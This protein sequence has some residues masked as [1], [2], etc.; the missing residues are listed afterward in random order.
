MVFKAYIEGLPQNDNHF[1]VRIPKLEDNT[2]KEFVLSA[3]LC[4]QPGEYANYK[5][6]D[7]VFVEFEDNLLDVPVIL[8]K[9]YTGVE[10]DSRGYFKIDRL[11]VANHFEM[12]DNST[13]GGYSVKDFFGLYQR[14]EN[15]LLNNVNILV[16]DEIGDI[17]D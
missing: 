16:Y 10:D 3:L 13:L 1:L 2:T 15:T 17:N 5:V 6:G 8:G 4:N 7:V 11:E 14:V 12:P 9:L